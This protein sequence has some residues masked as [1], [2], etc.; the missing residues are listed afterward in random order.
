MGRKPRSGAAVSGSAFACHEPH[1]SRFHWPKSCRA[2]GAALFHIASD[3]PAGKRARDVVGFAGFS[4]FFP[5]AQAAGGLRLSRRTLF[6]SKLPFSGSLES[7][8]MLWFRLS[9]KRVSPTAMRRGQRWKLVVVPYDF[10]A[11]H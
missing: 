4:R 8:L 9:M 5:S 2:H 6:A 3:I 7:P 11:Q 1:R 10:V